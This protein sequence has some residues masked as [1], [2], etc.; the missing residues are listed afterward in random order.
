MPGKVARKI[1]ELREAPRQIRRLESENRHLR[2]RFKELDKKTE[3]LFFMNKSLP[4]ETLEETKKRVFLEWPK[5]EGKMRTIQQGE[6]IILQKLNK[7]CKE[8]GLT[9]F[10]DAGTLLGARRHNGFIPW[11]DDIDVGLLREDYDKLMALRDSLTDIKIEYCYSVGYCGGNAV[12]KARLAESKSFWVDIFCF[13]RADANLETVVK[14]A[15]DF[16][17]ELDS[18]LMAFEKSGGYS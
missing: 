1:N 5:A 11:D 16:H 7:V 17:L 6:N 12:T 15:T 13:D 4:G 9:L 2:D 18:K 14:I 3:L 10:L 8:N